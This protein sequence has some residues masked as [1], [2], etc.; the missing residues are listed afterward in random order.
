MSTRTVVVARA[1]DF[2]A[3]QIWVDALH[4]EG[5]DARLFEQSPGAALGGAITSGIARFPVIVSE[6]DFAAARAV[7]GR[8]AGMAVL[9]PLP[10]AKA[11]DADRRWALLTV[12]GVAAAALLLALIFQLA[13]R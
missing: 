3:A 4:D 13:S 1:P 12:V 11:E 10:D 7:I 8:L 2:V 9:Q 5:I 6:D